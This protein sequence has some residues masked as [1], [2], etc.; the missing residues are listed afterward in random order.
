MRWL[1]LK[2]SQISKINSDHNIGLCGEPLSNRDVSL[3]NTIRERLRG[4]GRLQDFE[5]ELSKLEFIG[6]HELQ[7][8]YGHPDGIN[9]LASTFIPQEVLRSNAL[10]L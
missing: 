5:P 7:F 3:M 9:F 10:Y 2:P 1:G 8:L 4:L 6:K